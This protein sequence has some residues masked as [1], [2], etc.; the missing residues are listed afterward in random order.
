MGEGTRTAKAITRPIRGQGRARGHWG[1]LRGK[2]GTG[3][4]GQC[5]GTG[6]Q[7]NGDGL[8]GVTRELSGMMG[9]SRGNCGDQGRHLSLGVQAR[10]LKVG[11]GKMAGE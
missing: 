10:T 7:E 11:G 3:I 1:Q 4:Q 6:T 5:E 2:E 8:V 9:R